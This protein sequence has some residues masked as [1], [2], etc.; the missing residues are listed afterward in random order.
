MFVVASGRAA[1]AS[2]GAAVARAAF[3]PRELGEGYCGAAASGVVAC[4]RCLC[5][6]VGRTAHTISGCRACLCALRRA[7]KLVSAEELVVEYASLVDT[8]SRFDVFSQVAAAPSARVIE[9]SNTTFRHVASA[10][11]RNGGMR[12]R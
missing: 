9:T 1:A 2:G 4:A 6:A 10:S 8:N 11:A 7:K 12:K 5:L 3:G